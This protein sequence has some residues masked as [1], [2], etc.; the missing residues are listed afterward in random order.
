MR[1]NS[2]VS[3]QITLYIKIINPDGSLKTGQS[4]PQ[5][6]SYATTGN[7]SI[8]NN[9]TWD[10]PGWGNESQSNYSHGNYRIEV[11]YE[12]ICLGTTTVTLNY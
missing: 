2:Q 9:K 1:Y 6:Y 10:L 4:S 7:I 12:G 3:R 11:W 5:G 8:G